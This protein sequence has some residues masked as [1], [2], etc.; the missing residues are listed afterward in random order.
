M[1]TI[2]IFDPALCQIFDALAGRYPNRAE[3]AR[4]A[5]VTETVAEAKQ[6]GCCG[7]KSC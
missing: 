4:W 7:G 3:L 5:S 2:Q 1:K 6:V